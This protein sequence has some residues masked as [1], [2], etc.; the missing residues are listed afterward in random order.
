M[1]L[2]HIVLY[3]KYRIGVENFIYILFV[4]EIEIVHDTNEIDSVNDL[5][6]IS[7]ADIGSPSSDN[8]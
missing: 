7:I 5:N 8:S 1:V 6:V 3:L 4:S 2:S